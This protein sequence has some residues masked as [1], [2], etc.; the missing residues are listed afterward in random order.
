MECSTIYQ[1]GVRSGATNIKYKWGMMIDKNNEG[2][3]ELGRIR[4]GIR[5]E[6][7]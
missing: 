3:G 5:E 4:Q 2:I 1:Y 6:E 7:N